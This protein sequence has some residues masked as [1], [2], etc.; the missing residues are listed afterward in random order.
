MCSP[1]GSDGKET[2]WNAGR[3]GFDPWVGK[4]LWRREWLY[5]PVFLPENFMDKGAWQTK[6]DGVA[7]SQAQLSD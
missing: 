3:P 6:V 7:K 2:A 1:G 5:T 4:T